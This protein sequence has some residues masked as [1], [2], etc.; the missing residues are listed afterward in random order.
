[1]KD[2]RVGGR[3]VVA[4]W[5][6]GVGVTVAA[7]RLVAEPEPLLPLSG[8][9]F[10]ARCDQAVRQGKALFAAAETRK[11]VTDL[12]Y[13][14]DLNLL[15]LQLDNMD[16]LAGLFQA[17][18]PKRAVRD[19]AT[20]CEQEVAAL[21]TDVSMS[22]AIADRVKQ[23]D[24]SKLDSAT[25]RYVNK[26]LQDFRRAGV[27]KSPV[28]RA[29]IKRLN[30][31]IVGIGQTFSR[32]IREDV[33]QIRLPSAKQLA[34]LP[35]D[36]IQS[37][38]S[39]ANGEIVITTNY[40]DLIPYL[41]YAHHDESRK[42]LYVAARNRGYPANETVLKSLLVKRHQLATLLGYRD[43]AEYVTEVLMTKTPTR[44]ATF[45]DQLSTLGKSVADRDYQRLLQRL[46][47]IDPKASDV[48]AWQ[49]GYLS[50]L[51]K[52]ESYQV[53]SK[54]LRQYF[55]YA[56][57]K[58]GLFDLVEQM[59]SVQIRA[60]NTAVW[61]ESVEG[62]EI[63]DQGR[64]I[65]RFFLDMHPRES[66]YKHAAMFGLQS[67]ID[68][69]Q[70]PISVLVCNFPGGEPEADLMEFAQV[71][72]FLHEFGHLLH[73]SFAGGN[74]WLRLAGIQTEW[75]FVEAPSQMLE[76][77]LWDYEVLQ[78]FALN[79]KGE[80]I[81]QAL[82]DKMRLARDFGEGL[83][84]RNQAYYA[85]LSL[86]YYHQDPAK[87]D[88]LTTMKTTKAKYSDFA[89]V[90]GTHFY[91]NFGHLNGYSAI[92]YTYLW[93]LVIALDMFSEFE[94]E[95]LLDKNVANRYRKL[96]LA[97]GGMQDANTLV[98]QFLGRPYRI[99]AFVRRLQSDPEVTSPVVPLPIN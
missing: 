30:D 78:R 18:H 15:A 97:P 71:E 85:A 43:Y 24:T 92:Y 9:E 35:E 26:L 79:N 90:E 45:I 2:W 58:R 99:D 10:S 52:T 96:V 53:D 95:G 75:D 7:E 14:N 41:R 98:Q 37:H 4:L 77:W 80:V 34:G 11:A 6:F 38:S 51:I 46:H 60:W 27:D 48:K 56:R 13:L 39:E 65:A 21:L 19:V 91:A 94:A 49:S 31:E 83:S 66:K 82:V 50:E 55:S 54:Q 70:L 61:H 67:G 8:H 32:N 22:R 87:I 81:P 63:V 44:V 76:Q 73:H 86:N 36:Y 40:P 16:N 29:E 20:A 1:M 69:G 72:T 59:F 64:V 12:A 25:Q 84:I 57:V 47:Q 89:M 42:V 28:V 5:V 23:I 33:R 74:R 62:W 3:L 93:S 68:P 17:V 88:L